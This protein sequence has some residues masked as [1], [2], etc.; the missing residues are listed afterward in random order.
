MRP[1]SYLYLSWITA[2]SFWLISL[3][4]FLPSPSLPSHPI[5]SW[6]SFKNCNS[7]WAVFSEVFPNGLRIKVWRILSVPWPG[8][9]YL[10]CITSYHFMP[11]MLINYW[12]ICLSPKISVCFPFPWWFSHGD[13]LSPRPSV[14]F[15]WWNP[16]HPSGLRLCVL[17]H[18]L[19]AFSGPP[20]LALVSHWYTL[21]AN[22]LCK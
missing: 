5:E 3:S 19:V 7:D 17:S 13:P 12:T 2:T 4:V 20:R 18:S 14:S 6:W 1:P 8:P 22:T 11:C 15:P 16:A 10:S 9:A 21:R